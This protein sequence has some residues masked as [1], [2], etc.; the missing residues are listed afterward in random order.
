M[1]RRRTKKKILMIFIIVVNSKVFAKKNWDIKIALVLIS[2][3][4]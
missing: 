4:K 1:M 3:L 2:K